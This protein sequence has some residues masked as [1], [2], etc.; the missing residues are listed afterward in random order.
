MT[1]IPVPTGHGII[2]LSLST[3]C[4]V[5]W[6]LGGNQ[7]TLRKPRW[8]LKEQAEDLSTDNHQSSGS[9]PGPCS[10]EVAMLLYVQCPNADYCISVFQIL[11]IYTVKKIMKSGTRMGLSLLRSY[12]PPINWPISNS[13]FNIFVGLSSG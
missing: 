9:N 5:F 3:Y 6:E 4:N 10:C 8:T 1:L 2:Y 7:G 12:V 11:K 13:F